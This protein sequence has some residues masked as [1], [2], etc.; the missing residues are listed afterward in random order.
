MRVNKTFVCKLLQGDIFFVCFYYTGVYV[1]VCR[2]FVWVSRLPH[3]IHWMKEQPGYFDM[4]SGPEQVL[5]KRKGERIRARAEYSASPGLPNSTSECFR[6]WQRY[7]QWSANFGL[8]YIEKL[9]Q[10]QV[11]NVWN[12]ASERPAPTEGD[13][14]ETKIFWRELWIFIQSGFHGL[15]VEVTSAVPYYPHPPSE[16]LSNLVSLIPPNKPNWLGSGLMDP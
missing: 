16:A 13:V 11:S 1:F 7:S 8:T 15:Q 14:K 9:E 12:D 2:C 3:D 6:R 5:L 10:S 4:P